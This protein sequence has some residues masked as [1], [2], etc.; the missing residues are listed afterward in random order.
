MALRIFIGL[1]ASVS[2][3]VTTMSLARKFERD[4]PQPPIA[5]VDYV[6]I[7][8]LPFCKDYNAHTQYTK[9]LYGFILEGAA[10]GA[11]TLHCR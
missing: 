2:L 5:I 7:G 9:K 6:S 4:L 11:M 8:I 1:Q 3:P 10:T